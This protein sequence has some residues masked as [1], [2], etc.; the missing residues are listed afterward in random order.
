MYIPIYV[1]HIYKNKC[2]YTSWLLLYYIYH[3]IS[4]ILYD[5]FSSRRP[6]LWGAKRKQARG[7]ARDITLLYP[8]LFL[9]SF[10]LEAIRGD[11][12]R[13]SFVPIVRLIIAR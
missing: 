6:F 4:K 7:K 8:V 11:F 5:F 10:K 12:Y 3:G 2:F 9:L 1:H 13:S